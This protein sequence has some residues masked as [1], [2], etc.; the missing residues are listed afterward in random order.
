MQDER[1]RDLPAQG[2]RDGVEVLGALGQYQHFAALTEGLSTSRRDGVGP[3]PVVGKMPKHI[4]NACL[5]RQIDARVKRDRGS[6]LQIVR[7]VG[8]FRPPCGESARTA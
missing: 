7:R 5:R 2:R 4:L 1:W 3:W 8:R 6:H